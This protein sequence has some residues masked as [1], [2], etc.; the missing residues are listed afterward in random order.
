MLQRRLEPEYSGIVATLHI[1]NRTD[2]SFLPSLINEAKILMNNMDNMLIVAV[3]IVYAINTL[4][5]FNW[6]VDL[7]DVFDGAYASRVSRSCY[8]LSLSLFH[9]SLLLHSSPHSH[10]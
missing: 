3:T 4:M 5:I 2:L 8:A 10:S 9:H 1:D 6:I 7:P